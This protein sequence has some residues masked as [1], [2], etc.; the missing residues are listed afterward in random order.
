MTLEDFKLKTP[1]QHKEAL[2]Q[3]I[4]PRNFLG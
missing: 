3:A 2:Q 1:N 4:K